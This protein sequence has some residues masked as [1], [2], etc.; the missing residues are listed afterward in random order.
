MYA[1]DLALIAASS[2]C[3]QGMLDLVHQYARRWR[4]QL[5]STK[6]VVMVLGESTATRSRQRSLRMWRLG[7]SILG[8]VNDQHHLGILRSVSVSTFPRTNERASAGRSAF[9]A[10]N[11]IGS[12]FGSLHPLTSLKLYRSLC[13]PILLYGSE[14]WVLSKAE[15]VFLE[16]V[17]RKILRTIQ[18]LPT[19]CSSSSLNTLLGILS[20]EDNIRQR[21]LGFLVSTLS[22]PPD[23]LARQ[24]LVARVKGDATKGVIKRYQDLLSTLNLP[25]LTELIECG[26]LTPRNIWRIM[27]TLTS[28]RMLALSILAPATSSF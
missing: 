19:R 7:D 9:F 2:E 18:G 4:Y 3:L 17:H 13:L 25:N 22:L 26:R 24:I 6:S 8:E 10:L 12:R 23:S 20:I 5:N 21:M 15:L 11:S 28:W 14:L 16:R 1:D 27:L